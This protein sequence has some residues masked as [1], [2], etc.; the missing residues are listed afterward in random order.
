MSTYK[1]KLVDGSPLEKVLKRKKIKDSIVRPILKLS[2]KELAKMKR[3]S[4]LRG[5][6]TQHQIVQGF[7]K[8]CLNEN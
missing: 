7:I 6:L 8:A 4:G 1:I 5:N 2:A 3:K